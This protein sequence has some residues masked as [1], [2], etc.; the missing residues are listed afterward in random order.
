ML[1]ITLECERYLG[2]RILFLVTDS[3]QNEAWTLLRHHLSHHRN[4][5]PLAVSLLLPLA[6]HLVTLSHDKQPSCIRV[7]VPVCAGHDLIISDECP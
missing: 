5:L 3:R 2:L 1:Q 6:K 7:S 4:S